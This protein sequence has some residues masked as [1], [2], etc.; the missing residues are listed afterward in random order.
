[1]DGTVGKNIE[2][3]VA[4]KKA[5]ES[6]LEEQTWMLGEMNNA[7]HE[8]GLMEKSEVLFV[9]RHNIFSR[10]NRKTIA[11]SP[12]K[13]IIN[14]GDK[15]SQIHEYKHAF[16]FLKGE[17]SFDGNH[18][19]DGELYDITDEEQAYQRDYAFNPNHKDYRNSTRIENHNSLNGSLIRLA[20]GKYGTLPNNNFDLDNYSR[21]I[22]SPNEIVVPE[23]YRVK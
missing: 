18:N 7:L 10:S 8:I 4:Q 13:V 6:Q 12:T 20:T 11:T 17:L 9:A 16:Q 23:K 14:F 22:L 5:L 19:K 3:L 2:S 21:K 1:M 15:N